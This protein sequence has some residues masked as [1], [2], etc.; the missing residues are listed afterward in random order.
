M[1]TMRFLM[2]GFLVVLLGGCYHSE[3]SGRYKAE[4]ALW[5]ANREFTRLSIKPKLVEPEQWEALA[6]TYQ[7]LGEK[8]KATPVPS[9]DSPEALAAAEMRAIAAR[10][11]ARSGNLRASM[12]DSTEAEAIFRSIDQEF[13]DIPNAQG[14]GL[15]ALAQLLQRQSR[16]PE[17]I[18]AY[19]KIINTIEPAPSAQGVEGVVMFL[20]LRVARMKAGNA[21]NKAPFYEDARAYYRNQIQNPK[22]A[23]SAYEARSRLV[24][25]ASDLGDWNEALDQMRVMEREVTTFEDPPEDPGKIKF[26][27]AEATRL[28]L[29]KIE[30][31]AGILEELVAKYPESTFAARALLSLSK[32][33]GSR[34]NTETAIN[35]LDRLRE[36]YPKE[37]SFLAQGA[38]YRARLLERTG[39]WAGA[40]E[41]YRSLPVEHPLSEEALISHLEIA[42]RY[43]RVGDATS[44]GR[45]LGEAEEAY[46]NFI[47]RFPAEG[48]SYSAREKLARIYGAQKRWEEAISE[49]ES[50]AEA[51]RGTPQGAAQ[52]WAAAQLSERELKDTERA[53]KLY[54]TAVTLYPNTQ[55]GVKSAEALSRLKGGE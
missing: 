10:A 35:Y 49:L 42:S 9:G 12:G 19:E 24:D 4:E 52:L 5:K 21:Q 33:E 13:A 55:T 23:E 32:Y 14:T 3:F 44:R 27:M 7:E 40:L 51:L 41:A 2:L 25:V 28:G 1:K 8:Y 54:E 20:P 47:S 36:E 46:R 6:N 22:H 48:L 26:A 53:I 45:S 38:L 34:E 15:L 11:L 17:A 29:G 39:D 50:L 31:A 18:Q 30:E 37:D 43:D 16:T